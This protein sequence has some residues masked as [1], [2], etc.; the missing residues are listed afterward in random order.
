MDSPSHGSCRQRSFLQKMNAGK[1]NVEPCA[2]REQGNSPSLG[3]STAAPNTWRRCPSEHSRTALRHT[4]DGGAVIHCAP[5]CPRLLPRASWAESR[6]RW[7]A[8][9]AGARC[10]MQSAPVGR[11]LAAVWTSAT[12]DRRS[13]DGSPRWLQ[14]KPAQPLA[15]ASCLSVK[16]PSF[17]RA[18]AREAVWQ[19]LSKEEESWAPVP[20]RWAATARR[21]PWF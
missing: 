15:Y 2:L 3:P 8:S 12:P 4:H 13:L 5:Y 10:W 21:S 18:S 16:S 6:F 7:L 20:D 11:R 17:V 9:C 14:Q 19:L 1:A